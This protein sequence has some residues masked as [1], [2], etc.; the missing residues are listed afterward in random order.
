MTTGSR[1]T[2]RVC[3]PLAVGNE[4]LLERDGETRR[5]GVGA[6]SGKGR[7]FKS[8]RPHHP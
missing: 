8:G 3:G 2:K 6:I 4:E 1:I 5:N 7:R